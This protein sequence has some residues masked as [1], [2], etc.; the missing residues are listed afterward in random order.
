MKIILDN[1]VILDIFIPNELFKEESQKVYDLVIDTGFDGYIC[2][3][4]L[5]DIFY[6]LKKYKGAAKAKTDISDLIKSFNIIPLT[7]ED[8]ARALNLDMDDFEDAI[9][10]VCAEKSGV[11]YIIS[12]DKNFLSTQNIIETATP[13]EFLNLF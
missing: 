5:T 3:N 2:S 6:F 12:R 1:N 7:A 10:T 13:H 4:S 9:I 8:C 11:D